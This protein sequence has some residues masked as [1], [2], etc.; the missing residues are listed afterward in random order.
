MRLTIFPVLLL[1]VTP[2]GCAPTEF[3]TVPC[4]AFKIDQRS[5]RDQLVGRWRSQR[6]SLSLLSN[7]KFTAG[8]RSGCWDVVDGAS[9]ARIRFVRGCVN[10][11]NDKIVACEAGAQC[12]FTLGEHLALRECEFAGEYRRE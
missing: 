10:Y 12:A 4:T 7:G 9:G 3:I 6:E 8:V 11:G 1:A 2:V 5:S